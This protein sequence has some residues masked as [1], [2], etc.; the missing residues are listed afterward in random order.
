MSETVKLIIEIPKEDMEFIRK[1]SFVADERTMFKQSP[2]DRQGTMMLFRLMDSVKDGIS[3][4][5]IKAEI[6]EKAFAE[7]IFRSTFTE[8][9][10]REEAEDESVIE[11]EIVKLSDVLEILDNIGKRDKE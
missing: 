11:T 6:K 4:D 2:A 1:T 3:L 10:T 5:D 8:N 9:M 7:D